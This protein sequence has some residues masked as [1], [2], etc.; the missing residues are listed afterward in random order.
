MT[1]KTIMNSF[2][3]DYKTYSKTEYETFKS[4]IINMLGNTEA[5]EFLKTYG[6]ELTKLYTQVQT[7][8]KKASALSNDIVTE[9]VIAAKKCTCC[10]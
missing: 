8:D 7:Y 2:I 6:K 10:R 5:E 1:L 4:E 9:S 3:S